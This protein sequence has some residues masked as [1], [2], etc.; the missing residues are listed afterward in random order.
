MQVFV[1]RP[2][3]EICGND[4]RIYITSK[5]EK[6]G[7]VSAIKAFAEGGRAKLVTLEV[8]E[9]KSIWKN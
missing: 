9:L 3:I 6:R 1:D 8:H 2:M 5:R 4:G 7:E